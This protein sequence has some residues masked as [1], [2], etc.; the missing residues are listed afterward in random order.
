MLEADFTGQLSDAIHEVLSLAM[1]NLS[2]VVQLIL[3]HCVARLHPLRLIV[4]FL[5][6]FL[7]WREVLPQLH[8]HVLLCRQI[9][10][11]SQLLSAALFEFSLWLEEFLLL[12]HSPLHLFVT[13][14]KFLLHVLHFLQQ[15][16]LLRFW[17]L[18]GFLLD[19]KIGE[20]FLALFFCDRCLSLQL[21]SFFFEL[22]ADRFLVLLEGV[23]H[24]GH[25]LLVDSKDNIWALI[26]GLSRLTWL[27]RHV[28]LS[29]WKFSQLSS[30]IRDLVMELTYHRIFW[31]LIDTRLILDMLGT[32]SVTQSCKGL[33]NVVI[34]GTQVSDHHSLC[35]ATKGVL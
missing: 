10:L 11:H 24:L 25:L 27:S 16:L 22:F 21:C 9:L 14:Q 18:L 12:L 4:D 13:S 33:V 28:D 1:Y 5:K 2:D 32:R 17:L 6:F 31:V 34:C 15:L 30:Q 3:G 29:T 8:L 7:L 35:V 23:L 26:A 20:K 19:F